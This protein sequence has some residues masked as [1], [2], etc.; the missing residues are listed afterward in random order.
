MVNYWKERC[1]VWNSWDGNAFDND[2]MYNIYEYDVMKVKWLFREKIFHSI[3]L[4][5]YWIGNWLRDYQN[6]TKYSSHIEEDI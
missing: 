4:R 5:V 1:N 6:Y 3:E 2:G